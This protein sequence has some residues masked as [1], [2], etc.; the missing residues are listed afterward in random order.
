MREFIVQQKIPLILLV[1]L[2][3]IG[4]VYFLRAQRAK[5][6]VYQVTELQQDI[7]GLPE[8]VSHRGRSEDGVGFSWIHSIP[9]FLKDLTQWS[10][11]RSMLIIS[12]EPGEPNAKRGYTEQP[13]RL[14]VQAGFREIG[15]YLAL[16]E[17]LPRPVQV[18]GL[19]LES[20]PS[21][22]PDLLAR[23]DLVLYIK[24]AI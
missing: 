1:V 9:G 22:S 14:K 17:G 21:V 5:E 23:L 4:Y 3:L 10:Q 13:V 11:E 24:D 6:L 16:L 7:A 20:L 8:P 19:Q 18:T 15:N 12:V 2:A